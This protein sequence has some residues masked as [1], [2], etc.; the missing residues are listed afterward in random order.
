VLDANGLQDLHNLKMLALAFHNYE[1]AASPTSPAE[2]SSTKSAPNTLLLS[3]RVA[4]LPS[5]GENA[6]Y[7]K[8]DLTEAW[9]APANLPLLNDMPAL[10]RDPLA[11]A[12]S[13][14]TNY[15]GG[16]MP[17]GSNPGTLFQGTDTF[18]SLSDTNGTSN[19]IP[20][21]ETVNSSIPWTEPEDIP[22]GSCPALGGT[23]FSSD[24]NGA[25]PFAF[26]DGSVHL[27]PNTIDC[28]T[29][30]DLFLFLR[31]GPVAAIPTVNVVTVPEP[32]TMLL[33]GT[34]LLLLG[35]IVHRKQLR[36][37]A[38]YRPDRHGLIDRCGIL[39]RQSL[40]SSRGSSS[41]TRTGTARVR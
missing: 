12:G 7:S 2:G 28:T 20:L 32:S 33:F 17:A 36:A 6:L 4:I 15:V 11:P 22:I 40:N 25:V 34:G 1:T 21:G 41:S 14:N 3:W 8:F 38:E 30:K 13:T 18:K 23:G 16:S 35:I 9:N 37:K 31:N 19:T 26:A 24:I 39:V 29:L 5:I 10:F 27:L